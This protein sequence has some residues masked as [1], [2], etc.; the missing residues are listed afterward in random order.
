MKISVLVIGIFLS[1]SLVAESGSNNFAPQQIADKSTEVMAMESENDIRQ[2]EFRRLEAERLKL[3][4]EAK[5]IERRLNAQWW[6][7]HNLTQYFLAIVIT[8]ALPFGWALGYLEPILRKEGEV[9][10]LAE[11]RNATLNELIEARYQTVEKERT[12][13]AT[14]RDRLEKEAE[15][16]RAEKIQLLAERDQ[17]KHD[18][19]SLTKQ[20]AL[21][22]NVAGLKLAVEKAARG[23]GKFFSILNRN[24]PINELTAYGWKV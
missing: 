3:E 20:Q 21:K 13:I 17:L 18:R 16:L 9:N 12:D 8:S 11:Q 2:A 1:F 19:E 15:V 7:V 23:G 24:D 14:E 6:E 10:K 5:E 22:S 4:L